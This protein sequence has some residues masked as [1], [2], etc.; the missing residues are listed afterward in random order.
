MSRE[1]EEE[2]VLVEGGEG[3]K[4]EVCLVTSVTAHLSAAEPQF[5]V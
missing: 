5:V 3:D 4:Y 2:V 1:E